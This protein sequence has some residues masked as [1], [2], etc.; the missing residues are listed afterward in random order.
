MALPDHTVLGKV[1][2]LHLTSDSPDKLS[3]ST[4]LLLLELNR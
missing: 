2:K 1:K 4:L 3:E